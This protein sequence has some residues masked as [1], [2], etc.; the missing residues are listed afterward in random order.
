[1]FSTAGGRR[2]W[3]KYKSIGIFMSFALKIVQ[4]AL[5]YQTTL[6]FWL[7]KFIFEFVHSST[8]SLVCLTHCYQHTNSLNS[9][10]WLSVATLKHFPARILSIIIL[11]WAHLW[12][13]MEKSSSWSSGQCERYNSENQFCETPVIRQRVSRYNYKRAIFYV[14]F[15]VWYSIRK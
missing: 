6:L 8:N 2:L 12:V 9:L 4:I 13:A 11:Q 10:F 7:T 3:H 5:S 14:E 1:M 15:N